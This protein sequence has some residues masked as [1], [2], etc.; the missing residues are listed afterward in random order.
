MT[1]C[2]IVGNH[3]IHMSRYISNCTGLKL[4]LE[5]LDR[6]LAALIREVLVKIG[7]SYID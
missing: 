4:E 3:I 7:F 1:K 5:L 2:H 6:S